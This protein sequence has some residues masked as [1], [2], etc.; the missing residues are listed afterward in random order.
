MTDNIIPFIGGEEE[1]SEVEPL[2]IFGSIENGEFREDA[3]SASPLT[4]IGS[5]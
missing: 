3:P 5:R 1:K 4:A 2:K